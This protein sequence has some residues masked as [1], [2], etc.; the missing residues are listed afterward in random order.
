M[1][2]KRMNKAKDNKIKLAKKNEGKE[3]AEERKGRTRRRT[4]RISLRRNKT[5]K[6]KTK[7]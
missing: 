5:K 3:N 6:I 4:G 2:V 1:V 7:L